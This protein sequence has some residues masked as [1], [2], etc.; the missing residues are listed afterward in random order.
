MKRLLIVAT[1][2]LTMVSCTEQERAKA[3]GGTAVV[4]LPAGEKLVNVTWK[5]ESDLWYLTR[6]MSP[7]DSAEIYT[8]QQDKGQ[9]LS[10]TGNGTVIIKETR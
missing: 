2:A 10:I 6:K 8:F 4:E 9:L 1:L 3:L 7:S 5:D